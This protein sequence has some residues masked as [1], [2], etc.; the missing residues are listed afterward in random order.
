MENDHLNIDEELL[1]SYM[2]GESSANDR[3]VVEQWIEQSDANKQY[4]RK[5]KILWENTGRVFPAQDADVDVDRA[6]SKFRQRAGSTNDGVAISTSRNLYFYLSRI[7]AVFVIGLV[8]YLVYQSLEEPQGLKE[9]VVTAKGIT[10]SDT[11][12]DGS[13]VSLNKHS[14]IAFDEQFS[15]TKRLVS[16]RGEA[17]FDVVKDNFKPFVIKTHGAVIKVLGTS[18]YVRNYDS[19]NLIEVGVEEGIVQVTCNDKEV[20]LQAGEYISINKHRQEFAEVQSYD[21]N[22][23]FW[24]SETIEFEKERL[25][26]VFSTLEKAYN[27]SIDVDNTQILNCRLTGKF[28]KEPVEHVFEIIDANFGFITTKKKGRFTVSGNGCDQ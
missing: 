2:A 6:W 23:I 10:I 28:Y 24:M 18:F 8:I 19:L 7:A 4:F 27:I 17:F 14:E 20:I 1:A 3:R 5:L 12:P 22:D 26:Y 15:E 21:P 9:I 11:L 25:E 13:W 16:L